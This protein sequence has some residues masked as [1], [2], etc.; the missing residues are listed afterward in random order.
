MSHNSDIY[1]FVF[2]GLLTEDALDKAGRR[3]RPSQLMEDEEITSIL[4]IDSLPQDMVDEARK[5]SIV[6]TAIASFENTVRDLIKGVLQESH[7]EKWWIEGVSGNIRNRAEKRRKEEEK[8]RWHSQ[9]GS[10]PITYTMM[11]DLINIIRNNWLQFEPHIQSIDWAASI[12]NAI[13]RSRNVIMHS[14]TLE[15]GDIERLGIFIRDW[16][17]QVGI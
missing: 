9:R 7:G 12:I 4:S 8:I 13:D 2:K 14:G 6:Y 3:N 15:K 17:K 1:D 10:D 11:P 5:M 16:I